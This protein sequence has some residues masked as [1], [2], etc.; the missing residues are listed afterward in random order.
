M[1]TDLGGV[2]KL[3]KSGQAA[4]FGEGGG[5]PPYSLTKTIC[6]NFRPFFPLNM[7]P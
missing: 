5:S 1:M 6:E 4:R 2:K 3:G 7:I